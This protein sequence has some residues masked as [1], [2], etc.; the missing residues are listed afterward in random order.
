MTFRR[1]QALLMDALFAVS[2]AVP[3]LC[4]AQQF[5]VFKAKTPFNEGKIMPDSVRSGGNDYYVKIGVGDGV[6]IGTTLNV[7][8]EKEIGAEDASFKIKTSI[9]I[10]RMKAIVVQ[11][12]YIIARVTELAS[13]SD[14][15]RDRDAVLVNDFVQPVF[16][17]QSENLFDSGSSVLRP[18]AIRELD[19]AA[20]FI[21][22]YRPIKVRV[23][24][25]TDSGGD[26]D[27]NMTLSQDRANSVRDYL[28]S[29]GGID[30]SVLIPVGYGE[31]KPVA[32]DD[33]PENQ[34]K[35]R[36]FEIVIE[37]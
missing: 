2:V 11:D 4:Y 3:T 26:E 30:T 18:E 1:F 16:V 17:V 28:V 27:L 34:R 25:H 24:G 29:Q 12:D 15:H 8:R 6:Q 33:T 36:R 19:R 35:N 23:E 7:Y 20:S 21:K 22:R 13:Y 10:G 32:P 9:F 5:V 14:P 31:S 37:R